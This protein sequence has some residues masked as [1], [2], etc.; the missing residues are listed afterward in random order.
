MSAFLL[1]IAFTEILSY[2]IWFEIIPAFKNAT[3]FNPTPFMSHVTYNPILAFA[4]YL[5]LHKIFFDKK[6]NKFTFFFYSFIATTM[7]INMF[8][9]GGR[10]GHESPGS[11][12][13]DHVPH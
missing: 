8:I 9:T 13:F 6:L 7:T 1:A 4:I 10:A 3:V 12:A 2:L 5:V 11:P